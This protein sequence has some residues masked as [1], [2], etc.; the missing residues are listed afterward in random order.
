MSILSNGIWLWLRNTTSCRLLMVCRLS[1]SSEWILYVLYRSV[2]I[3]WIWA[4]FWANAHRAIIHK[5]IQKTT[6]ISYIHQNPV[7]VHFNPGSPFRKIWFIN[8]QSGE[9]GALQLAW[10]KTRTHS[11]S[12]K[13]IQYYQNKTII[14]KNSDQ[15]CITG[16]ETITSV[17]HPFE[18]H[19]INTNPAQ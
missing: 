12:N 7:K 17:N 1:L 16:L 3:D 14:G 10:T 6:L 4:Q 11:D 5:T 13:F 9:S 15:V 18:N 8:N 19:S 2:C